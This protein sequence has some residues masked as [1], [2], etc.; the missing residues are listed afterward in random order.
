M[1]REVTSSMNSDVLTSAQNFRPPFDVLVLAGLG[2]FYAFA[3]HWVHMLA[4]P[5][6]FILGAPFPHGVH[7]LIGYALLF[8]SFTRFNQQLGFTV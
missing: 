4:S 2:G 5:E 3:P 1:S 8:T 6:A 7:K